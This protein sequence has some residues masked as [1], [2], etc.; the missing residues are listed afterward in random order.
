MTLVQAGLHMSCKPSNIL[1][2]RPKKQRL[3]THMRRFIIR[4]PQLIKNRKLI[5]VLNSHRRSPM[6]RRTPQSL[7]LLHIIRELAER[8]AHISTAP[9]QHTAHSHPT[10]KEQDR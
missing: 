1:L 5:M 9:Q 2:S 10:A 6:A 4:K 8:L 7:L 3:Q